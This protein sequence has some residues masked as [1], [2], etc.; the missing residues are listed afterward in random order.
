MCGNNST[1]MHVV[2]VVGGHHVVRLSGYTLQIAHPLLPSTH[3]AS[4]CCSG[5]GKSKQNDITVH[6]RNAR[7]Q[8]GCYSAQE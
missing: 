4:C 7:A 3:H 1:V 6:G 8:T 5:I 2:E